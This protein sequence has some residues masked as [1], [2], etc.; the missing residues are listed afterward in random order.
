MGCVPNAHNFPL[1]DIVYF[2]F[3]IWAT[4]SHFLIILTDFN[5]E[6]LSMDIPEE[7]DNLAFALLC[8]LEFN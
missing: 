1:I 6:N 2:D 5:C 7:I 8:V 4:N 3:P